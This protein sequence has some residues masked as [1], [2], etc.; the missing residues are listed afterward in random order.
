MAEYFL[1]FLILLAA[2][3]RATVVPSVILGYRGEP[4]VES[5]M[6]AIAEVDIRPASF[7][8][9]E[10]GLSFNLFENNGLGAAALGV[11]AELYQPVGLTLRLAGQHQQ[12]SGWQAGENRALAAI[13]VGP[14][15][16]LDAAV[17][18][19]A[20]QCPGAA[21]ENALARRVVDEPFGFGE[22][23]GQRE[24][25]RTDRSIRCDVE[26]HESD[27]AGLYT[28]D[29]CTAEQHVFRCIPVS[30]L[31]LLKSPSTTRS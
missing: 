8:R 25:D 10:A 12:W 31:P 21:D 15:H 3:G 30:P 14:W 18:E 26:H 13:G 5:K 1:I 4:G 23:V 6:L 20:V 24:L 7:L 9:T 22:G 11:A 28:R 16:G 17:V 2:S 27:P 29:H 19:I